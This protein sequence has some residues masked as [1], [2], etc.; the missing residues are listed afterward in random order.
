MKTI[1]QKLAAAMVLLVFVMS[2]VPVAL[3]EDVDDAEGLNE[4][5]DT[6]D[7]EDDSD[8]TED[9]AADVEDEAEVEEN[10]VKDIKRKAG[11]DGKILEEYRIKLERAR[12]NF[13]QAQENYQ[14][15]K[16]RFL[17]NKESL[18]D[19]KKE[20][21]ACKEDGTCEEL[22]LGLRKGVRQHLLKTNE[23]IASS[24]EKLTAKIED[25]EVLTEE[26]KAEALAKINELE[27]ELTAKKEAVEALAEEATN[28]ELKA[29]IKELKEVWQKVRK[30]QKIIVASLMN[31]R[32]KNVI[33]VKLPDYAE[34]MSSRIAE[35]QELGGDTAAMEEQQAKYQTEME[36]LQIAQETAEDRWTEF[37]TGDATI[38]EWRAAHQQVRAGIK[39]VKETIRKFMKEYKKVRKELGLSEDE[40]TTTG[41][42]STG[43]ATSEE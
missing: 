1:M 36:N 23:L 3:A 41:E 27:V 29:A 28:E 26:E 43:E 9:T 31:S 24:L 32:L 37:K 25:S 16:E 13:E 10:T 39:E 35:I 15:A 2:I 17:N 22:K 34:A 18:A 20:I 14:A 30:E 40:E 5:E 7:S 4:S 6:S 42:E 8:E 33:G 38:E 19:L 12:K 11:K 21:K